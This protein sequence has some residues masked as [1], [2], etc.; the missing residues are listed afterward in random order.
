MFQD[1]FKRHET[2]RTRLPTPQDAHNRRPATPILPLPGHKENELLKLQE[3]QETEGKG[4]GKELQDNASGQSSYTSSMGSYDHAGMR[5]SRVI[6]LQWQQRIEEEERW[7]GS[8][9][10]QVINY[11]DLGRPRFLRPRTGTFGKKD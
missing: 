4:K 1:T 3:L 5:D 8:E 10:K 6:D 7:E 2:V 9:L 11:P